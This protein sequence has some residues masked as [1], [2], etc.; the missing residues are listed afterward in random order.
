MCNRSNVSI[1]RSRETGNK[2]DSGAVRT[3]NTKIQNKKHAKKGFFTA[4]RIRLRHNQLGALLVQK[5]LLD[6]SELKS[7]IRAQRKS[8]RRTPLGALLLQKARITRTQLAML[9]LEQRLVRAAAG[10]LA[11]LGIVTLAT[12]N[13]ARAG[14]IKDVPGR[15]SLSK[16]FG[17]LAGLKGH[18]PAL[19]GTHTR[20]SRDLS[21]FTK[22]S[23]MFERF[24]REL[25]SGLHRQTIQSWRSNIAQYKDMPL[26]RAIQQVNDYV[27]SF[28]YSKDSANWGDSDYWATPVEFFNNGGDCEDYA[29]AKYA[30]LRMLGVPESRMR[31]AIVH[32][33]IKNIPHAILIVYGEAHTWLLDNQADTAKRAETTN[34]Y[35]PIYS[36]NRHAWWLH[37]GGDDEATRVAS[38]E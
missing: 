15:I 30:S 10:F 24:D 22:W 31:L 28:A 26:D 29:I 5:G 23:G 3:M 13:K 14:A 7:L 18:V 20:K 33:K 4:L 2:G 16:Q 11:V 25:D 12:P 35:R 9:L 27:N 38:A 6:E 1:G 17:D 21:A 32:D 8:D 36:I 37:K 34:R 19:F